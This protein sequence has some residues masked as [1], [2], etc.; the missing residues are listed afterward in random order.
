MIIEITT[1][2]TLRT[3]V[4]SGNQTVFVLGNTSVG[5]GG[6][7]LYYWNSTSTASDDGLTVIQVTGVSTGRWL[8]CQNVIFQN[9]NI[10][11]AG[12]TDRILQTDTNGNITAPYSIIDMY[13]TDSD[14]I[15]AAT[16][17]TYNSGNYFIATVT[18]ANS[19]TFSQ[20][21]KY[22]NTATGYEYEAIQ[23]NT[24]RRTLSQ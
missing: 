24:L 8:L 23:D 19:K 4:G 2:A 14:L 9:S 7:G 5:D 21:T 13:V 16:G 1:I 22:I 17:A 15:A 20:G 6:A 18:P 3:R 12:S 10:P 11:L